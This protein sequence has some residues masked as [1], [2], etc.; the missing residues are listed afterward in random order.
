M[1][2]LSYRHFLHV[3][4]N[5]KTLR[6]HITTLLTAFLISVVGVVEAADLRVMKTGL[7][8]GS[9]SGT[10][11]ACGTD[12]NESFEGSPSVTLNVS[13]NPGSRFTSWGGDCASVTVTPPATPPC[14][15][16]VDS[17]R[18][19]RANFELITPIPPLTHA[20]LTPAGIQAYL[21]LT[22]G[23]GRNVNTPAE[24]VAALPQDF[25]EN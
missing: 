5:V 16:T 8:E 14:T 9:I 13:A 2:N 24:F 18:S 3:S 7:G 12:C 21:D 25:K 20:D 11:I 22:T 19:V 6:P 4:L 15:V 17:L 1:G 10:G 23:R